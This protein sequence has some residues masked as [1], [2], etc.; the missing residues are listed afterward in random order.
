MAFTMDVPDEE[1]IKR[2][3]LEQV[4]PLPEDVA[5]LQ[6]TAMGNVDEI[7]TLDINEFARKKDI[8]QS[9]ESFGADSMRRSAAKNSLLQVRVGRLSR[10]SEEGGVV[11]KGLMDLRRE[12]G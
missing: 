5:R 12:M 1:A 7:M 4:K 3:V 11:A 8:L 10:E 6:A 9:I 2:E